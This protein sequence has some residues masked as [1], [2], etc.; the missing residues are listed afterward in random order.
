[1]SSIRALAKASFSIRS[2]Y[3]SLSRIVLAGA[4]GLLADARIREDLGPTGV[5]WITV[6]PQIRAMSPPYNDFTHP[7]TAELRS[8]LPAT[9]HLAPPWDLPQATDS[10][11]FPLA[12]GL[13]PGIDQQHAVLAQASIASSRFE[14]RN[15]MPMRHPL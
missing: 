13:L 11:P 14:Q 3:G 4:R 9:Q 1:M 5:R 7:S 6:H 8:Y 2:C 15:E 10:G 12:G